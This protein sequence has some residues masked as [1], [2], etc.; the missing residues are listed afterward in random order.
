MSVLN[1]F[2]NIKDQL[3][4]YWIARTEQE[5]KFL[6][7]GGIAAAVMLVYALGVAPALEGRARLLKEQPLLAQQAAQLQALAQEAGELA[8]QAPPQ[9]TPMTRDSLGESLAARS[10]KPES[11]TMTGEYA[12]VQLNNVAFANVYSWLEAQRR[13]NRIAVQDATFTAG[14]PLGQVNATLTLRQSTSQADAPSR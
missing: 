5:R 2:G 13:E 12:K 1:K 6:T 10:L 3:N 7:V 4:L 14:T 9:V 11:L 8:R